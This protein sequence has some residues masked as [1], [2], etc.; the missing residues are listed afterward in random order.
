MPQIRW[1]LIR[2]RPAVQIV[3]TLAQGGQAFARDLL[4]DT[5]AGSRRARIDLLLDEHDCL[6]CGGGPGQPITLGGAYSGSFPTYDLHVLIPALGFDQY[7]RAVA[8]PQLP[9]GFDG[10]A[11]FRFLSGFTYGNFGDPDQFG[12]EI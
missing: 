8:V 5:G 9:V 11:C 12:L 7:L 1:Q 4:A 6:L 3:L 10:V 2:G